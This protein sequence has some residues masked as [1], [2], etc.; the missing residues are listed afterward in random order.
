METDVLYQWRNIVP[1]YERRLTPIENI[2]LENIKTSQVQFISKVKGQKECPV[3]NV[4]LKNITVDHVLKEE[5]IHELQ[6]FILPDSTDKEI[7][8]IKQ[9]S[10]NCQY[11]T[12]SQ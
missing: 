4:S 5:L 7:N 6:T 8:P 12:N 11:D 10:K 1:T 2:Y 9:N 3:K